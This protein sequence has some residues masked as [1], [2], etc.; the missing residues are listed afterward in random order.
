MFFC[1]EAKK[2]QL[3]ASE[4]YEKFQLSKTDGIFFIERIVE[5][6]KF[7]LLKNFIFSIEK[8]NFF[9]TVL[10]RSATVP[11]SCHK[12]THLIHFLSIYNSGYLTFQIVS[13]MIEVQCDSMAARVI[14]LT[15]LPFANVILLIFFPF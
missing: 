15:L 7:F 8:C 12:I 2:H 14:C 4:L 1:K 3:K 6:I 10:T 5:K 9:P 13:P 11:A